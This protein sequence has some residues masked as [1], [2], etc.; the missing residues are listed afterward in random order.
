MPHLIVDLPIYL[1]HFDT[2]S[3]MYCCLGWTTEQTSLGKKKSWDEMKRFMCVYCTMMWFVNISF[4]A[5]SV[6]MLMRIWSRFNPQFFSFFPSWILC[7]IMPDWYTVDLQSKLTFGMMHRMSQASHLLFLRN[8]VGGGWRSASIF[9][10][11]KRIEYPQHWR[12]LQERQNTFC[13]SGNNDV[14]FLS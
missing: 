5:L 6:L 3:P 7:C 1:C 8:S 12:S 4:D 13:G 14:L 9:N 11:R 2:F 10:S